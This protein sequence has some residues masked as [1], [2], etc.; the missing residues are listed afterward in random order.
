LY[1]RGEADAV[2]LALRSIYLGYKDPFTRKS[3]RVAAPV[4]EFLREYD[5][6]DTNY[7]FSRLRT[8]IDQNV[9]FKERV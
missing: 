8:A 5:F 1:G 4:K 6:A 2:P 7:D 9:N 3:V